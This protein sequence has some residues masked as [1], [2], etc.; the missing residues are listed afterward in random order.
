MAA[1]WQACQAGRGGVEWIQMIKMRPTAWAWLAL[2]LPAS[3][4]PATAA[5]HIW[6][7]QE[8]TFTSARSWA[9]AYTD[10]T[11]F[12][13]LTGPNFKKRIY[14]FWDGGQTFRVRVLATERSVR[15][16]R[17]RKCVS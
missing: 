3:T 4:L 9:N 16:P 13:D 1:L 6:D 7:K 12:V 11:V 17:N 10:V 2:A 14:G 15:H 8:L 5:V